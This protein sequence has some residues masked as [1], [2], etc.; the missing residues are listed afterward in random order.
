MFAWMFAVKFIA[1][2]Q[3][4]MWLSITIY[5]ARKNPVEMIRE[6]STKN[7]ETYD[8]ISNLA[9]NVCFENE[10]CNVMSFQNYCCKFECCSMFE[11]IAH[12]G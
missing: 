3:L 11:F 6:N 4:F 2:F 1:I 12:D 9:E 5:V 8:G 10:D 7:H